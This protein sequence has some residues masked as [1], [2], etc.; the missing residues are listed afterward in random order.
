[1][2]H[3]Y[4]EHRL[5]WARRTGAYALL[6]MILVGGCAQAVPGRPATEEEWSAT[7]AKRIAV[8][9]PY[10]RQ[11]KLLGEQ[12]TPVLRLVV[13]RDGAIRSLR[14]AQ[15]SGS[16]S[17]D[18]AA[19][20]AVWRAHQFP[21]FTPDMEGDEQELRL[22][23]RFEITVAQASVSDL[24]AQEK[25]APPAVEAHPPSSSASDFLAFLDTLPASQAKEKVSNYVDPATGLDVEVPAPLVARASV[26]PK[27]QYDALIDVNSQSGVPPIAG[28]SPS[29]CSVGLI[30]RGTG[31]RERPAVDT[32]AA[33]DKTAQWAR[34]LFSA[35][36][37]IEREDTFAHHG[38]D[39]VEL[40]I[41]P[42]FG[43]GH[44]Y[45]RMYVAVQEYPTGRVVVSCSTH[46][47]AMESGLAVFRKVRDGVSLQ[48]K[49]R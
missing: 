47:D 1:M 8:G 30:A 4:K 33:L 31:Q 43:S 5:A 46:V 36:G 28:N 26:R 39:G 3:K 44:A 48:V 15:S 32:S 6:L 35:V 41:A 23:M 45:Q 7:V 11:A 20:D 14:L 38:Q 29:L 25:P 34:N 22:P 49:G 21:P 40:V 9:M 27:Q 19:L 18:Q 16:D 17:L 2:I 37:E 42:R 12:G 10:P 13:G 24:P